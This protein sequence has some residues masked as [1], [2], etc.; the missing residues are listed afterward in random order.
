V[1]SRLCVDGVRAKWTSEGRLC[2]ANGSD[3]FGAP[4]LVTMKDIHQ[5]EIASQRA[6][7][8]NAGGRHREKSLSVSLAFTM[9]FALRNLTAMM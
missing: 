6:A 9:C 3:F 8:C 7:N 5:A 2:Y 4:D 1:N